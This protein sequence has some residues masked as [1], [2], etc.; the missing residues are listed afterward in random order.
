MTTAKI[1]LD[2]VNLSIKTTM[3]IFLSLRDQSGL[4]DQ[5]VLRV[6]QGYLQRHR[7]SDRGFVQAV[8]RLDLL[9]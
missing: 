2:S 5:S 4:K 9:H 3:T 8:T 1:V 6:R 7:A